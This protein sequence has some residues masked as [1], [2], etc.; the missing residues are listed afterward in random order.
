MIRRPEDAW[1][2]VE[3][4]IARA[5]A[6]SARHPPPAAV[7]VQRLLKK[8]AIRADSGMRLGALGQNPRAGIH[9]DVA[10]ATP[11]HL[12]HTS[13]VEFDTF[14]SRSVRGSKTS[15]K[16]PKTPGFFL[17]RPCAAARLTLASNDE[18]RSIAI[19]PLA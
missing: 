16:R 13:Q 3:P 1:R 6:S 10:Y 12:V 17:S 8:P 5:I 18:A 2:E 9:W 19:D 11:G 14:T 4:S 7:T 15:K